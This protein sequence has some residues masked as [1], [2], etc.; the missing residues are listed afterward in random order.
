MWG[1]GHMQP[2]FMESFRAY[3]MGKKVWDVFC[4]SNLQQRNVIGKGV[5]AIKPN[6]FSKFFGSCHLPDDFSWSSQ[7]RRWGPNKQR[8]QQA[9]LAST[10]FL[11]QVGI[12]HKNWVS[13]LEGFPLTGAT[14]QVR[15]A[16]KILAQ[17]RKHALTFLPPLFTL[18]ICSWRN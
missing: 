16:E 5:S 15:V 2:P 7:P 3:L 4:A 8:E 12:Q 14:T 6:T 1:K 9:E 10:M 11:P 13:F 18:A 17:V